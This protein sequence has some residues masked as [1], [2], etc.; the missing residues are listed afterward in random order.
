MDRT[1]LSRSSV[2][3]LEAGGESRF[4]ALLLVADALAVPV[5]TLLSNDPDG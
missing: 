1:G 5:G 4:S 2:Q 3:R